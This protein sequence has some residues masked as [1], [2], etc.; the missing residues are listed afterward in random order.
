MNFDLKA[1]AK[2]LL[3]RAR[4]ITNTM[5]ESFETREHWLYQVHPGANHAYWIVAHLALADNLF[6]TTFAPGTGHKPDGWDE[7]F[8]V[9]SQ[10][11]SDGA[12]YP[13]LEELK[14]YFADR[15]QNLLAV[16][17]DVTDEQLAA[18]APEPGARSPIA[19]APNMGQ[20]LLF[21]PQHEFLHTGQLSVTRRA[22]GH[23]PLI[24]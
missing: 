24:G 16:I 23:T 2:H 7:L 18:P 9:G 8:W 13:S 22:L 10:V 14:S 15:R 6:A 17:E 1:H 5:L 4:S 21:A 19:G 3:N 12:G 20:L 11:R